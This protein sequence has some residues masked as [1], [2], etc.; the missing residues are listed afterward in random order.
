MRRNV[1]VTLLL[2]IFSQ[3][4]GLAAAETTGTT[5]LQLRWSD[6]LAPLHTLLADAAFTA[7]ALHPTVH[8]TPLPLRPAADY[9]SPLRFTRIVPRPPGRKSPVH[10]VR[11]IDVVKLRLRHPAAQHRPPPRNAT[12]ESSRQPGLPDPSSTATPPPASVTGIWPWWTY[13]AR[14]IPGVGQ[15]MVNVANLNFLFEENDVDIPEGGI[16][17]AFRRIYNSQSGHNY[18]NDDGAGPS[19][20]GNKWTNNLDAHI[21]FYGGS[22]NQVS[23][24][25]GDGARDDYDCPSFTQAE[26]CTAITPGIHD[27]LATTD[28]VSH[29][30][31]QFQWTKKSGTSYIFYA[32]YSGCS[33]SNDTGFQGRLL[34]IYARNANFSIQLTYS[35]ANGDESSAEN[36]TQ[37]VAAHEPDGNSLTLTFGQIAGANSP[38]ELASIT[39][40]DGQLLQYYYSSNGD[41]LELTK[42]GN[43]PVLPPNQPLPT[44]FLDGN[45]IATGNLPETYDVVTAGQLIE[46]CSPR[47]TIS[48]IDTNGSPDRGACIDFDYSNNQL[49]DWYTRG[50]LNP[51]PDDDVISQPI[52]S[53]PS[54]GFVQWNDTAY[55]SNNAGSECN[56]YT[57]A[58]MQDAFGHNV[59]WCYDPNW[60]VWE[61]DRQ[62]SSQES[63]LTS[64]T[65]D[66]SNNLTSMTDARNY[67]ANMAYDNNGNTLEV[68]LP[69]EK[70]L[71][72]GT[73]KTIRPTSLYD[74][75]S[76]NNVIHYCDPANNPNNAWNPNPGSTPCASSGA[77]NYAQFTFSSD[78]QQ[79]PDSNEPYGCLT[80]TYTPSGYQTAISYGGTNTHPC[81]NGLPTQA[82]GTTIS[83]KDGTNRTPTQTFGYGPAGD[84]TSYSNYPNDPSGS[85]TWSLVY[86]GDGMHRLLK[87]TDPDGVASHWCYNFDGSV[88]YTETAYQHYLDNGPAC[89]TGSTTVPSYA[90]SYGYD[91][92][93]NVV[94][95]THHHNCTTGAGGSCLA[96]SSAVTTCYALSVAA[97]ATCKFYDGLDRLVEVKQPYD[98]TDNNTPYN[99]AYTNPW[100]T[101]YLY[102]L[103]GAKY[104]FG[105]PGQ[106]ASFHAYGNLF[107]TEELLPSSGWA[108]NVLQ[109]GQTL[110]K[111]GTYVPIKAT[112]YDGLDRTVA[113]Y[114][115]V[116][117]PQNTGQDNLNTETL[118][119]DT[120]PLDSN[121]AGLLGEDCNDLSP[122]QCQEFDYQADGKQSTFEASDTQV[123]RTYLY[124]PDDRPAQITQTGFSNPQTYSY[125]VN[126]NLTSAT[127]ASG[128]SNFSSPATLT[129]EYYADGKQDYL[130]VS[131][132]LLTQNHLRTYSY[133]Q[134]GLVQT[135]VIDDSSLG[136]QILNPG[137]T[138]VSYTYT[139]AGRVTER[140][141]SGA[142]ANSTPT[143][144][145]YDVNSSTNTGFLTQ[146]VTPAT[147][148]TYNLS[149]N[150]PSYSA[151]SDLMYVSASNF[152]VCGSAQNTYSLRGEL[153]QWND[154]SSQFGGAVMGNGASLQPQAGWSGAQYSWDGNMGVMIGESGTCSGNP[155]T[156]TWSF[157]PAGR[158]AT[159]NIYQS[160]ANQWD[161]TR[162]YDA[163]NH[164][165]TTSYPVP[166]GATDM[167]TLSWGPNG[168][169]VMVSSFDISS[170]KTFYETLHWDGNQLLFATS[171][172]SGG[173]LDDVKIDD[174]GD[175][176][177]QDSGYND[178][179]FF[180][181]GPGGAAMGCHNR[182][183]AVFEGLG[184]SWSRGFKSGQLFQTPCQAT[185]G[186]PVKDMP[187][188][189]DWYG[190]PV[191]HTPYTTM[192][193]GGVL[194]MPRTDALTDGVDT[195]QGVRTYNSNAG[196]WTT[197][198]AYEGDIHDPRS[199]KPFIWNN[200]NPV[201]YAD[202]S[203]YDPVVT[204]DSTAGQTTVTITYQFTVVADTG[205]TQQDISQFLKDVESYSGNVGGVN[206]VIKAE[207]ANPEDQGKEGTTTVHLENSGSYADHPGGA[208][209]NGAPGH[210][211]IVR[212]DNG[213]WDVR[214]GTNYGSA[215]QTRYAHG[216]EAF[217]NAG[218]SHHFGP[219]DVMGAFVGEQTHLTSQDLMDILIH[220]NIRPF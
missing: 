156:S 73:V 70:I 105:P 7:R 15:A 84:L 61:T 33:T 211:N 40:P 37:I 38:N 29:L 110:T 137:K 86:S 151:E 107:Q 190:T 205:V 26:P 89:Q 157:D 31:C 85:A 197:P 167:T 203:G 121:V 122:Q 27:I 161:I 98:N 78:P 220:A 11:P 180:D 57:E 99:E 81:S 199:Q 179:T 20:F 64:Q 214:V 169:P 125:G 162:T 178:L 200:D 23:V 24:Y 41:L 50:V 97:G 187:N 67:T 109:L 32:P 44:K 4:S 30:A 13:E 101:R 1:A 80:D 94:T 113:K 9:A 158:M 17:L 216:H 153:V 195:I 16:D 71:V 165:T 21:W 82:Q 58:N 115:L 2:T 173:V 172:R 150:F 149:G 215:E 188:S 141:E 175:I 88:F 192:G 136:T 54:T 132:S 22:G 10:A 202:L 127:E 112:A 56:P 148:L 152:V 140:S 28:V 12:K 111:N 213:V 128:A 219:G 186:A 6:V 145:A 25:T 218:A 146:Q 62:V 142:A 19:I 206:V 53:G 159:E 181:R 90:V 117:N 168:H 100:I 185:P 124:D 91:P 160:T 55:F 135:D 93:G 191:G 68:S 45:P 5:P 46:I 201:Q 138:T 51:T 104:T 102:D 217:H 182:Q 129:Y 212:Y 36:I 72:N 166:G 120:S 174:T 133:R 63:L 34:A 106:T 114:S 126:G 76:Y 204:V 108:I 52:Q 65:W 189:I 35:W 69:P 60:L 144:Y 147:T 18:H 79:T 184:D 43:N 163:E 176:T 177:P 77:T 14:S 134:D 143:T 96:G 170:Q 8:H 155:C 49:S 48:N 196:I 194:G 103:S 183:K 3:S 123:E 171:T 118:T 154:C 209:A 207:L 130:D 95:E 74:Y 193:N 164:L 59:T 47:A 131:S 42:P 210:G 66:T 198:D 83:Q 39:R 139:A 116:A 87:R 75:D 208:P 92:D 119:W